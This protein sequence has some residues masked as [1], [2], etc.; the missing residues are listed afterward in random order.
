MRGLSLTD[1]L[2]LQEHDEEEQVPISLH[3]AEL[4]TVESR[5]ETAQAELAELTDQHEKLRTLYVQATTKMTS[6]S[7]KASGMPTRPGT[8][9]CTVT[10]CDNLLVADSTASD[11]FALVWFGDE[12]RIQALF[13]ENGKTDKKAGIPKKEGPTDG[14]NMQSQKISVVAL[15]LIGCM[16]PG[17]G[18]ANAGWCRTK[19]VKNTITPTFN[20]TFEFHIGPDL[21]LLK[22]KDLHLHFRICDHDR[23]TSSDMLGEYDLDLCQAF[24]MDW[25]Q[26]GAEGI[27]ETIELVDYSGR[28]KTKYVKRKVTDL[29]DVATNE[30]TS[31]CDLKRTLLERTIYGRLSF[32]LRFQADS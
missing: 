9:Y 6:S 7:I 29:V 13:G 11:P 5:C 19:V 10:G 24:G 21:T 25:S 4:S 17:V 27:A 20:E 16:L 31:Q 14:T 23:I 28:V 8:I 15:F 2:R 22:M 18:T 12:D 26:Y 30:R 3:L 32:S 1:C